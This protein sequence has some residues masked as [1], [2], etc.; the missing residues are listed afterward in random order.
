[1]VLI[2]TCSDI[3][4]VAG[5]IKSLERNLTFLQLSSGWCST[6]LEVDD[7]SIPYMCTSRINLKDV[8]VKNCGRLL[9]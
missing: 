6:S 4:Y 7:D 3:S 8:S 9:F 5:P 1:M 2:V